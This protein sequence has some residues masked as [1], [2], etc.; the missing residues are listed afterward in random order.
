MNAGLKVKK[1]SLPTVSKRVTIMSKYPAKTGFGDQ[2][3]PRAGYTQVALGIGG[4]QFY[5]D[6]S[7]HQ[8]SELYA[9]HDYKCKVSL[10]FKKQKKV[11]GWFPESA[12]EFDLIED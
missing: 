4:A 3:I 6:M 5:V 1:P 10:N 7:D 9:G 12:T 11:F 8:A 2:A